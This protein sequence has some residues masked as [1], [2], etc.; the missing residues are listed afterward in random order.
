MAA[1]EAAS[2]FPPP[3]VPVVMQDLAARLAD[4]PSRELHVVCMP[5]FFLDHFVPMPTLEESMT[6]MRG[7]HERG[8]GNLPGPRHTIQA[9]GNA[10]N[11]AHALARLGV[12]VHLVARTSPF[13]AV[14]LRETL[15]RAGVDLK[16]VTADGQLAT[17]VALEFAPNHRN[18]M[19]N[20]PGSVAEFGP[21]D[22]DE[23]TRTLLEGA[24]AV[25]VANWTL[26][27]RHGTELA[28]E[29]LRCARRG[30]ALT[31]VDTGDPSS[32][33]P[34]VPEFLE[35]VAFS[36][37]LDVFAMNENELR[38]YGG[39][40]RA[41][42]GNEEI[43]DAAQRL[44]K[45]MRGQLDVHTS[46][47]AVTNGPRGAARVPTFPVR[48]VRATGAGDTWNA[49]NLIGYMLELPPQDRLRTA[50]AVA[51]LYLSGPDGL[52]PTLPQ[53]VEYVRQGA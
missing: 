10:A 42:S 44:A 30:R 20:D 50:N 40:G 28:R 18:V 32:R 36:G 17:T 51:G 9:G 3:A 35:R 26:S 37:D 27:R 8:G 45:R 16:H 31:Y 2:F 14:Y 41:W 1:A 47:F 22:L 46:A 48:I 5:D 12:H 4:V 21:Q 25:L 33:L 23:N 34:D 6:A 7:V 15:G 53:L 49:G 43:V 19:L 24:H 13:G 39:D 52:P 38:F 29:A 11:T